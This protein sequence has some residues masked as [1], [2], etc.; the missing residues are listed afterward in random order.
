MTWIHRTARETMKPSGL[1]CAII[2]VSWYGRSTVYFVICVITVFNQSKISKSVLSK[3]ILFP[4]QETA[5]SECTI[6]AMRDR[7]RQHSPQGQ[8]KV[9]AQMCLSETFFHRMSVNCHWI[10]T[11]EERFY[12]GAIGM[13]WPAYARELCRSDIFAMMCLEISTLPIGVPW[14]E[15]ENHWSSD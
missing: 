8:T 3:N 5:C 12:I 2:L 15:F 7:E 6:V 10:A 13:R 14:I 1:N 9:W 11:C 4:F